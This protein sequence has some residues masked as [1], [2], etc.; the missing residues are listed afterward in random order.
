MTEKLQKCRKKK[1]KERAFISNLKA[2]PN[3]SNR[4]KFKAVYLS[5][6]CS[7]FNLRREIN[8]Q[9]HFFMFRKVFNELNLG[10]SL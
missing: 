7:M 2:V 6:Q 4:N 1:T 8:L 5:N 10:F 9:V 3:K